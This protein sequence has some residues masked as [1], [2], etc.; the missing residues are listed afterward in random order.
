MTP[1]P[2]TPHV[3]SQKPRQR[4]QLGK[5]Q[6]QSECLGR[7]PAR[8]DAAFDAALERSATET[9]KKARHE[10]EAFALVALLRTHPETLAGAL[11]ALCYVADW[12]ENNDVGLF[13]DWNGSRRSAGAAFL[14]MI[15]DAIAAAG[16]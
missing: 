5:P 13:H 9:L 4:Q 3:A 2:P 8:F 11:A 15:A 14:P 7:A 16:R 1:H 6:A 12:A 10:Q